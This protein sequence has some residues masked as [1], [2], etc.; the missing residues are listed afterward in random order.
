[1]RG[2]PGQ[3]TALAN[4][5][6]HLG[7]VHPLER[8]K[9]AVQRLEVV[10]GG[11]AAEVALIDQRDRKAAQRGIPRRDRTVKSSPNDD[12][13]EASVRQSTEIADHLMGVHCTIEAQDAAWI[14]RG[15]RL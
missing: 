3:S 10:G 5:Q 14:G 6:P 13:I 8:S 4:E 7:K 1:M 12:E 15:L 9:A 11:C 2:D